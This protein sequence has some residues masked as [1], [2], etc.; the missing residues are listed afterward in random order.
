MPSS[1]S[2]PPRPTSAASQQRRPKRIFWSEDVPV[3][4]ELQLRCDACGYDLTGLERRSCP[5]C[6]KRF[7]L[8]IPPELELHCRNCRYEL[9]GLTSRRCPEC[10]TPFDPTA[11]LAEQSV[12]KS[13]TLAE[14]LP[15]IDLIQW[16]AG[17][18]LVFFGVVLCL[19]RTPL[20]LY[21]G[22]MGAILIAIRGY[23]RGAE[24][25]Q[26]SIWIGLFLAVLG[27]LVSL[28]F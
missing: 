11:L 27:V 3:P 1:S 17:L 10:G 9:S 23:V 18:G 14:R 16:G 2:K 28:A 5:T 25:P 15:W 7:T 13:M 22:S 8:P 4:V 21:P 6:G 26:V 20:L 19:R 24:W 12:S